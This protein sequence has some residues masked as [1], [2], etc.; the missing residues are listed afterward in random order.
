MGVKIKEAYQPLY[1]SNKRY[2]LV[3]GG[4]GSLKSSSI[5]DFIIRLTYQ[6]GHGILFTRYTMSSAEESIIPH[7]IIT[8]DRLGVTNNFRITKKRIRNKRTGSFIHFSG[9]KPPSGDQTAKLKGMP[10]ITTWVIDEGEEFASE[11]SFIDID[12]SI[13]T[14]GHKNRI[15]WIQNPTTREHFIYKKLVEPNNRKLKVEGFD[16]TVSNLHNVEHI[17]TTYHLAESL[18]YLSEDW[19]YNANQAKRDVEN[20]IEKTKSI[21]NRSTEELQAEIYKIWHNS[22]YYYNYIG[23]WLEKKEGCIFDNW[24][25]GKFDDALPYCFGLDY[26]YSPNPLAMIKVA[27]DRFK[28]RIYVKEMIYQTH[29]DDVP[30]RIKLLNVH[31]NDLIVCDIN[32]KRTTR[33]IIQ[34]G[35]NAQSVV[36]RPGSIAADIREI[37]TYTIVVDPDSTNIK[38]ELNN[39]IWNDKRASLPVDE[40]NDA[41]DAMRYGFRRLVLHYST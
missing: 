37:K 26:G 40:Y 11:K 31:P 30:G 1:Y 19:L 22:F 35:F 15:I 10:G 33:Q 17:H 28:R 9:V 5:N 20:Q 6:K 32:E 3:T 25:E 16:V 38:I 39:Y 18:G 8:M 7:I 14:S 4:R 21:W 12:G 29:L 34:A 36:K 13:R 41:M 2:F 24:V 23:G 27:V